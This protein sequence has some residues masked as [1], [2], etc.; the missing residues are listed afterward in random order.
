MSSPCRAPLPPTST[1]D[2]IKKAV[3]SS[4]LRGIEVVD[5]GPRPSLRERLVEKADALRRLSGDSLFEELLLDRAIIFPSARGGAIFR[6]ASAPRHPDTGRF[7]KPA[8]ALEEA[9]RHG[10]AVMPALIAQASGQGGLPA[11]VEVDSPTTYD[12]G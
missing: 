2:T 7:H 9:W 5:A 8:A 10:C 6:K 11:V 12:S 4:E 3:F 1:L